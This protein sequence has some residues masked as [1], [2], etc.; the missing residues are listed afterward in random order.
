MFVTMST[1]DNRR[2]RTVPCRS[3]ELS[4]NFFGGEE[5]YAVLNSILD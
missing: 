1:N 5:T 2:Y 3:F 4:C